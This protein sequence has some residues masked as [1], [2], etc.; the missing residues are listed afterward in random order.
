VEATRILTT[1]TG[2]LPRP[3]DITE[4]L[5]AQARGDDVDLARL[6]RRIAEGVTE[7][8][9]KQGACGIDIVNDGETGKFSYSGYVK[10]RLTGFSR[11]GTPRAMVPADMADFPAYGERM[12]RELSGV[13]MPVC[14]GPI[15]YAG[16]DA[17]QRDCDNLRAALK[18]VDAA[19]A[20]LSAASP[21][22][23]ARFIENRHYPNYE[24]YLEALAEAMKMEYD[25]IHRAGFVL[26]VDCPELTGN[27]DIPGLAPGTDVL[28]LH[29]D[30]LNAALRDIPPA[31]MRIH[32]CWGNYEGP[33]H[34]DTP[35]RNI[36]ERIF[37][38]RPAAISVEASNPRHGHEWRVF[39]DIPLPAGRTVIP[40]VLDTTTN[41]IEHP[42]LVA[43]R[44]EKYA[45]VVG[46]ERV[47][48]GTDCGFAT[49]ATMSVVDP[50][51]AWA[52]LG[53]MV[54]GARLASRTLWKS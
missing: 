37:G 39:E 35:L 43:Q 52:K 26:Q 49:F 38:A 5:T 46:R 4:L 29:I 3:A 30:V 11:T 45:S 27:R 54:E 51:I 36:V 47:M 20:F 44:I 18:G 48:A 10:E 53:A 50:D 40:G 1:H 24:T 9:R 21:G 34:L 8:V 23:I 7:V 13:V 15:A 6:E 42:E 19:G 22:V 2:S 16:L 12:R 14:E 17:V 33:H 31:A 41:F 25:A 28:Q 32:L